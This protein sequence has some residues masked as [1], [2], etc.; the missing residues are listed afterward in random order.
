[1]SSGKSAVSTPS[2]IERPDPNLHSKHLHQFSILTFLGNNNAYLCKRK[3]TAGGI[4]L[5]RDPLNL[6]NKHSRK[7]E[8][9]VNDKAI[10]ITADDNTVN[11]T[12][13]LAYALH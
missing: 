5:S 12:F 9:F 2:S 3:K 8:G 13:P 10:G 4:M 6:T 1:M 7:H 11:H